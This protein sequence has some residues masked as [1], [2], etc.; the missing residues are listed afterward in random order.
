MR[1]SHSGP[2]TST[3][4]SQRRIAV[5]PPWQTRSADPAERDAFLKLYKPQAGLAS[6]YR[7]RKVSFR[8]I[9]QS[10][11]LAQAYEVAADSSFDMGE[12]VG[13]LDY[14]TP[15]TYLSSRESTAASRPLRMLEARQHLN[16]DA[17]KN[18]MAAL[19]Y[20]HRFG[21]PGAIAESR[22]AGY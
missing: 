13:G 22:V 18:A 3:R 5:R 2:K 11:F 6:C 10:A 1:Q 14:A 20:F 17:I 7:P 12:Y 21:R 19:Y 4:S 15:V 16:G 9:P 8:I